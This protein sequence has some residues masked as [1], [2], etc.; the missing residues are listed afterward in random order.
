MKKFKTL[1]A[2]LLAALILTGCSYKTPYELI[3]NGSSAVKSTG[4]ILSKIGDKAGELIDELT[5]KI[6]DALDPDGGEPDREDWAEIRLEAAENFDEIEYVRPSTETLRSL[7]DELETLIS[8]NAGFDTVTEKLDEIYE[9]YYHFETMYVLADIRNCLDLTDSFYAEEYSV[10][11]DLGATVD[12]ILDEM[13]YACGESKYAG[14]LE[15]EYFWE[16]FAEEYSDS[17]ESKFTDRYVQLLQE[18]SE[19]TAEYRELTAEMTVTVKGQELDIYT[20][21]NS[22]RSYN[23]YYSILMAYYE[24]YNSLLGD[25]FIRLVK[26]RNAMAEET[27]Y[28]SYEEMAYDYLYERDYTPEDADAYLQD[29]KTYIVPVYTALSQYSGDIQYSSVS[30][31]KLT[32][33]LEDLAESMGDELVEAVGFM[34]KYGLYDFETSDKK[35]DMSFETYLSDYESPFLFVNAQGDSWD[36]LTVIHEFGHYCDDYVNY[37]MS[38][39]IDL[40]E[41]YS[42]G[43]E[44]LALDKLEE[45]CGKKAARSLW[46]EKAVDTAEIYAMQGAFAAFESAVYSLPEDE[47]TLDKINSLYL[48]AMKDFGVAEEGFDDYYSINWVDI[49]HFFEAPVYVISY[50][51]SIDAALQ[52]FE[53][54]QQEEGSGDSKYV[55]MLYRDSGDLIETLQANGLVSPFSEGRLEKAAGDIITMFNVYKNSK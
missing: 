36:V 47:L 28:D 48:S 13:Y 4:G 29:I 7:V 37:G 22:A 35:A 9:A 15:E 18:E 23:E 19:L 44:Y 8:E 41:C 25:L 6:E 3:Q 54:E 40:A 34:E 32:G 38:E 39:S 33:I 17:S 49:T 51:V 53:L 26:V 14:K 46:L 12:D 55:E 11:M 30:S 24:K 21:L 52:L 1:T 10:C 31:D 20:A 45:I 27:G 2:I 42:Q 16:G 50:T 5:G 43:L